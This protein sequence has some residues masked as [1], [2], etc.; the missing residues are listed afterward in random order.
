[1]QLIQPPLPTEAKKIEDLH[2]QFHQ[3]FNIFRGNI[4]VCNF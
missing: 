2:F 1:M 3:D 4:Y